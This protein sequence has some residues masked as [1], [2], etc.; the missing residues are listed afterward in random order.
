MAGFSLNPL[1]TT[2]AGGTFNV[3]S[4]GYIQGVTM[5]SPAIRNQLAGGVVAQTETVP[6]IGGLAI[7]EAIP[8][9][10]VSGTAAG[11]KSLGGPISRA[12]SVGTGAL[13]ITGFTVFDQAHHMIAT[14]QSPVPQALQGMSVHFYRLGSGA[15]IALA[16]D[17]ALISL[18]GGL[19]TQQVSWDFTNQRVVA[20]TTGA[21]A[22]PIR[23]LEVAPTNCMVVVVDPVTG[24]ATWNRNGSCVLAL[25]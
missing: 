10:Y 24:F 20:Y 11:P 16:V 15:R 6:M 5:D 3:D 21:G 8:T 2:N 1:V 19:I 9:G 14:P 17:P 23:V 13:P 4:T 12:T 18:Q 7:S 22:A 25:I